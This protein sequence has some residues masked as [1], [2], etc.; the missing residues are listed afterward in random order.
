MLFI[1]FI[2]SYHHRDPQGVYFNKNSIIIL[3]FTESNHSSILKGKL[4]RGYKVEFGDSKYLV[5]ITRKDVYQFGGCLISA[6]II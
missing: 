3:L 6:L 1:S 2:S 5:F 4:S